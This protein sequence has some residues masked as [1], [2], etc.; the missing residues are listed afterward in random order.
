MCLSLRH[1]VLLIQTGYQTIKLISMKFVQP[2]MFA[3]PTFK[4]ICIVQ[5]LWEGGGGPMLHLKVAET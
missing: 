3:K 5:N 2:L 1:K 4:E